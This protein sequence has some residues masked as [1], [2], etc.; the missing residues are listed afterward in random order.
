[1]TIHLPTDLEGRIRAEVLS[2]QFASEEDLVAE[3]VR[4]Y[5]RRKQQT[6]AAAGST[7]LGSIGAMRE[8]A[9]WLDRAV[10]HAMQV[11][12]ERPWRLAP[13]E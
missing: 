13:G 1:M 5:F 4:E 9:E 11:R 2:G 12:E 6:P 8:D 3:A 7:S 10:E